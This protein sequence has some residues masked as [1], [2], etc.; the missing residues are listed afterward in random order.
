MIVLDASVVIKWF[1]QEAGSNLALRFKENLLKNKVNIAV[2]DLILYEIIN[3]LRFKSGVTE[4]AIKAI[5]P[6]L[7]NLGL[8]IITPSQRLLED[9]LHLSFASRLSI[10]DCIYV[11][12]ANELDTY[13]ITADKQ[14]VKQASP[15]SKIKL[16]T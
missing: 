15:I 13:F 2:P 7:F 8:E 9:A 1:I 12:L 10:Y 11:A 4:E 16:L 3:V 5:L 6:A 14:I